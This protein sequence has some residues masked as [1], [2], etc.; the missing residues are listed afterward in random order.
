MKVRALLEC[1]QGQSPGTVFEVTPE[2]ADVLV[3]SGA[4]ERV[5]D[6][7]PSSPTPP[8]KRYGR[9]DLEPES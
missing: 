3:A 5:E 9:R 1:P 6:P 7:P 8:R 2:I 4:A